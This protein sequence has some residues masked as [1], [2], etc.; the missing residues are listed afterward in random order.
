MV[1]LRRRKTLQ[2]AKFSK[3]MSEGKKPGDIQD[4]KAA[5]RYESWLSDRQSPILL[6]EQRPDKKNNEKSASKPKSKPKKKRKG[7]FG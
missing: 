6:M 3:W 2:E 4:M 5:V 7:L 1:N